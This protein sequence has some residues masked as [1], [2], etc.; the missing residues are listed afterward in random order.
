M[1]KVAGRFIRKRVRVSQEKVLL[2]VTAANNLVLSFGVSALNYGDF[3][4]N[5]LKKMH[6]AACIFF[7]L[8]LCINKGGWEKVS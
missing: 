8:R 7:L 3:T 5:S 6:G 1:L 4:S 2:S